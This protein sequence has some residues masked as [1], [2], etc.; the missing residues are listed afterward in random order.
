M[1]WNNKHKYMLITRNKNIYE[2]YNE[3]ISYINSNCCSCIF[4]N[5]ICIHY[6]YTLFL[7]KA[8]G[9]SYGY[10]FLSRLLEYRSKR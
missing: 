7:Y 8:N 4:Y 5:I 9:F 3:Y 1:G 10:D 2:I 6:H